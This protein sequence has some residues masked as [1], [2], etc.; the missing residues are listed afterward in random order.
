MATASRGPNP[1][2]SFIFQLYFQRNLC[3][4]Q[5]KVFVPGH[6]L[7][8]GLVEI[9]TLFCH[10]ETA[11][12]I[13]TPPTLQ[14]ETTSKSCHQKQTSTKSVGKIPTVPQYVKIV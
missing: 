1:W 6:F 7:E 2:I 13:K 8:S 4:L 5:G 11:E 3:R 9:E 10:P 14:L 12:T